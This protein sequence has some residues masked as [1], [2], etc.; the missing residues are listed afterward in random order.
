MEWAGVQASARRRG[1][2]RGLVAPAQSAAAV[3]GGDG[4]GDRGGLKAGAA[5]EAGRDGRTAPRGW[6]LP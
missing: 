5:R 4:G 2:G 6:L 1:R 3:W